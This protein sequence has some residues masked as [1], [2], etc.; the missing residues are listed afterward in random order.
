MSLS[1]RAFLGGAAVAAAATAV[2][3]AVT[4][5]APARGSLRTSVVVVGA[6]FAGLS[7][8]R[9]LAAAGIETLVLEARD[10]V[11]GRVLNYDIGGGHI[12]EIGGQWLGPAADIPAADPTT[13]FVRGQRRVAALRQ[14]VGLR[15]FPTYDNGLYVDYTDGRRTTYDGRIPT[16]D[17]TAT[18]EAFKALKAIDAMAEQV[19]LDAPWT[20]PRAKAWDSMTFQSFMDYGD[21]SPQ[22]GPPDPVGFGGLVTSGGR[23]LVEL[24]LQAV[25]SVEPR[26]VSLLHVIFYV[27]AAGS[28]E[29]LINTGGGAQQ[30]RVVGGTQLI[31]QRVA[32]ALGERIRLSSPVRRIEQDGAGVVVSGDG[33]DVRADRVIVAVPP[34]IAARIDYVPGLP[35]TRDQLLQRWPMGSVIKVQCVYDEPFWRADG[36]AGQTTSDT[37]PVRVTFDNS[38]PDGSP[39]VLMG[40]ME[41]TDGRVASRTSGAERRAATI[42]SFV[43]YFGDRAARP[44]QYVEKSWMADPYARGCYAGYFAPGTWLDYGSEVR[45]PVGRIHWAGTETATEWNGYMDGAVQSGQRAAAEVRAAVGGVTA[46]PGA[47]APDGAAGPDGGAGDGVTTL[48]PTLADTGAAGAAAAAGATATAAGVAARRLLR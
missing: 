7:A 17:P 8:A 34:A 22:Y 27:Q 29:A 2:P 30:D 15:T 39:G 18:A 10:R 38:P 14:A 13:G 20:A 42:E 9:D 21:T 28:F 48:R 44:E 43:R 37:G 4:L 3:T 19:P 47:V 12:V 36:L 41:G 11:G 1:R 45:A 32:A 16:A 35:A 25:F 46:P 24:A 33:F 26:D 5:A 6:G 31:A 40:F 23:A